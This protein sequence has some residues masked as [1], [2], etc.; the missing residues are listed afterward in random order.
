MLKRAKNESIDAVLLV[1][2]GRVDQ[3]V[4]VRCGTGTETGDGGGVPT[5]HSVNVR[6]LIKR[7]AMETPSPN[8][9]RELAAIRALLS[10]GLESTDP[11]E[12][13]R[14]VR[15]TIRRI[16]IITNRLD[17]TRARLNKKRLDQG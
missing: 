13:P 9:Q 7:Q 16:E 14:V 1:T 11:Q 4:R 17:K 10:S 6:P 8:A 5:K 3:S 12:W 2:T 15:K